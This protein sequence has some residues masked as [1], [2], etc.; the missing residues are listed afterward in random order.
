[1]PRTIYDD[2]AWTGHPI[3]ERLRAAQR[4]S[5]EGLWRRAAS[6]APERRTGLPARCDAKWFRATFCDGRGADRGPDD[7]IWDLVV[8]FNMYDPL[9]L[10]A[11]VPDLRKRF[12]VAAEKRVLGVTHTVIGVDRD[13]PGVLPEAVDALRDFMCAFPPFFRRTARRARARAS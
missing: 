13:R 8:S 6:T 4:A 3:G 1:M 7:A 2:M 5:I 9:A 12:F 11:C 10:I